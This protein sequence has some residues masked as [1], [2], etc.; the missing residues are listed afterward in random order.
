MELP[1]EAGV[2]VIRRA[3]RHD[4]ALQRRHQCISFV[5]C[6]TRKMGANTRPHL[7]TPFRPPQPHQ[8]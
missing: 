3:E 7:K 4:P 5:K 6:N 8:D 1:V 2:D